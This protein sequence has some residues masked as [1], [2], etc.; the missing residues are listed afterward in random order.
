MGVENGQRIMA[1]QN[2]IIE[3]YINFFAA[4]CKDVNDLRYGVE[5]EHFIVNKN[6]GVHIPYLGDNGIAA[7]LQELS[8]HFNKEYR[9]NEHLLGFFGDDAAISLEPGG[10]LE[11]SVNASADIGYLAETYRRYHDI[12]TS[13]LSARGYQLCSIGYQ[14]ISKVSEIELLPRDRYRC[15]DAHFKKTG[16]RGINMMRG[17]ASCQVALD[18][19]SEADFV[20]K[21][22]YA[23]LLL[24]LLS[25]ISSNTPVFE[26]EKNHNKL[27]RTHIWRG[28]DP[29]RCGIVPM[30]F[31]ADFSFAAYAEYI[32]AQEAVLE[33]ND[34]ITTKSERAVRDVLSK[35]TKWD[36][37][38]LLY[39]SLVF[40]DVRLRQY[41]EIRV[42]DAMDAERTFAYM[43]LIKGLF[44]DTQG[45]GKWLEA[46]Y[47]HIMDTNEA[48]AITA[49]QDAIM[50]AGIQAV[51][52]GHP[53]TE[54]LAQMMALAAGQ[55][56]NN[57]ERERIKK[58]QCF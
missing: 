46:L 44:Q 47:P 49:A 15:M 17:T 51:V 12:I 56:E 33:I 32:A 57:E 55:L 45:L 41:I 40:P 7:F 9:E 1:T 38:Y 30:T 3:N 4:G 14:P 42:A 18:Y 50:A 48:A 19:T 20:T 16:E 26:G 58:L 25:L 52:Y 23:Y 5:A 35:R 28:V 34:G 27:I 39:L 11:L 22:R 10:Q 13:L 43:A 54:L 6:T 2:H 29:A 31:A 21:Y 8:P 53:V 36:E 24:P 37:D